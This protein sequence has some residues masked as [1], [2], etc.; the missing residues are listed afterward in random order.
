LIRLFPTKASSINQAAT[1]G[2][3]AEPQMQVT[4][5]VHTSSKHQQQEFTG[6]LQSITH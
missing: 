2:P 4:W 6:V 1:L 5:Q 3:A